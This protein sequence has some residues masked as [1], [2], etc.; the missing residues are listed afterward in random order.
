MSRESVNGG[1]LMVDGNEDPD[2]QNRKP[3]TQNLIA[4]DHVQI[5]VPVGQE[6]IARA[7][8]C[9]VLG[10]TEIDKPAS[11]ASRGGLWLAIG[12][13]QLHIGT[14]DG[15]DRSRTKA[16]IAYQVDDLIAWRTRLEQAGCVILES[17]PIPG[18]DRFETRDP[19]AN[20]IEFI[21]RQ[22]GD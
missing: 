21:A 18:H 1:W 22:D 10:L 5:T 3:K 19:F 12:D 16:H 7:F 17:V 9:G 2:T 13:Q 14:E 20:R 8:Y 15:V 11:L 4:I 6:Q